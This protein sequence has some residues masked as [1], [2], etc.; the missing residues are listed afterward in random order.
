MGN[1]RNGVVDQRIDRS[2]S[3]LCCCCCVQVDFW[4]DFVKNEF[5]FVP[6][7]IVPKK[8]KSLGFTPCSANGSF[9]TNDYLENCDFP[10]QGC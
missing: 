7:S 3:K 6:R 1:A 8:D 2:R 4:Y 10:A 9:G 5:N